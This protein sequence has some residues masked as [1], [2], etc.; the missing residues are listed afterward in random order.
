MLEEQAESG[1]LYAAICASPIVVLKHHGLLPAQATCHSSFADQLESR[2]SAEQAV[3]VSGSCITSRGPA[4][5]MDF[6]LALV[7][8]LCGEEKAEAV[9]AAMV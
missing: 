9:K 8:L 5:A 7:A 6:A 1:R 2:D 3:V 4:T